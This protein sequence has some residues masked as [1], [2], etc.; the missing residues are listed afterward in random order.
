VGWAVR[1]TGGAGLT[2][3]V[4]ATYSNLNVGLAA[5]NSS[6]LTGG[7]I[8]VLLAIFL[9]VAIARSLSK[10]LVQIT[11]AAEGLS[12]GELM[13]MPSNGGREISVLSVTFAEMAT[14][15]RAKQAMLEN[16]I[17]HQRF[18]SGSDESGQI[19]VAS[20]RQTNARDRSWRR[21]DKKAQL[22]LS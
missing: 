21:H 1:L 4:A 17:K 2:I 15:I 9:A 13:A 16:T 19:V 10:P 8:A 6:A 20:R 18:G 5:V 12:R 11:R 22:F 14:K 7:A 3:L